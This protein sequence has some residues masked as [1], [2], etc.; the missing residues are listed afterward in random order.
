MAAPAGGLRDVHTHTHT[1]T[2]TPPL[3]RCTVHRVWGAL[4]APQ[5]A[6][7]N[8][9][10]VECR[11]YAEDPARNFNPSP[12]LL[13]VPRVW[14]GGACMLCRHA[15]AHASTARVGGDARLWRQR[16]PAARPG[17]R[18]LQAIASHRPPPPQQVYREP[19]GPGIRV[20]SGVVEVR[21]VF[22]SS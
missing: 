8:Q 2:H 1:H 3:C 16:C 11:I 5:A 4:R 21:G 17:T 6:R 13:K 9:H 18:T 19:Q 14:R 20:D 12:G 15:R 22:C 10:A 7:I